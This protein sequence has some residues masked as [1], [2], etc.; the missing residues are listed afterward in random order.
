MQFSGEVADSNHLVGARICSLNTSEHTFMNIVLQN[1]NH[2]EKIGSNN[3]KLCIENVTW[4]K[5]Y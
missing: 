3:L 5:A 1:L 4:L 2:C